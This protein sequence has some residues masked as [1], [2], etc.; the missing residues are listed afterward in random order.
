MKWTGAGC[1][2][3]RPINSVVLRSRAPK[4]AFHMSTSTRIPG[5]DPGGSPHDN[6]REELLNEWAAE[7]LAEAGFS[8]PSRA[9]AR[10]LAASMCGGAPSEQTLQL[11]KLWRE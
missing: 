4:K 8:A 1:H 5:A 3:A 6:W 11:W 9:A 7:T 2:P 10:S